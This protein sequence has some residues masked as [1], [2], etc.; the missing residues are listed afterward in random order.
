MGFF[1]SILRG[2]LPSVV[3][4]ALCVTLVNAEDNPSFL[5]FDTPENAISG[6]PA[7]AADMPGTGLAGQLLHL[8]EDR[9]LRLGG[10][11]LGDYN[12]LMSG[13]AQ[14]GMSSWNSALIVGANI[15]AE[16]LVGWKGADF[17]I[18]FLQ[19][20]GQNTNGQAG[21]VQGYNSL[22]ATPPFDRSELYQV[23]FRQTLFDEKIIFKIGQ[24]VPTFDFNNVARPVSTHNDLLAIPA[25]TGL[26]YTP[27]YV[28]P[29][30][31]G[32]IPG[33]YNSAAGFV[34]SIAPTPNFYLKYGFFDGNLAR[35]EQTGL[36]GPSFNGY[37]FNIWETGASWVIGGKYPGQTG[38][39]MWYQTGVLD[40]PSNISQDGTGG[41][42]LFG[43]QRVWGRSVPSHKVSQGTSSNGK[44]KVV[45][46]KNGPESHDQSVSIF[47]QYGINNSE[48]L[49]INQSVGIGA[50]AFGLVPGRPSDSFGAGMSL[51]WLNPNIFN[52]SSELMFQAYYQLSLGHGV[53]LQ[54]AFTYIPTPGADAQL[55]GAWTFTLRTTVLF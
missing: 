34:V 23:W 15:D 52:R 19:F 11:W 47:Y 43:G 35:G 10:V 48:T 14:P 21:S 5:L 53:F 4:V 12:I 28:T 3:A 49:P 17:G 7:A 36:V 16:K 42:Y 18:Q 20:N 39:G 2:W 9:G 40:G 41:F 24:L 30:L 6:N 55:G 25:V 22:V 29:S 50:T 37:S 27:V 8:P 32:A 31:L 38:V 13:G 54:P 33:Y 1:Q 26:L 46:E 44:S 45:V 51:A